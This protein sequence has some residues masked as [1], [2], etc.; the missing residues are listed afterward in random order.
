FD[1][2]KNLK[3]TDISKEPVVAYQ[4]AYQKAQQDAAVATT[5]GAT[6]FANGET[7]PTGDDALSQVKQAAYDYAKS[8]YEAARDGKITDDDKKNPSFMAGVDAYNQSIKG[9]DA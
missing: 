6:A 4:L 5:S 3:T 9:H 7:R 8:G 2:A 1:D